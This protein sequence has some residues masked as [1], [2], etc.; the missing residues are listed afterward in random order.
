MSDGVD[1]AGVAFGGASYEDKW[2]RENIV[3]FMEPVS[4][5][6]FSAKTMNTILLDECYKRYVA[7]PGDDTT[8]LTVY[9]RSREQVNV[10]IGPPANVEDNEKMMSLFFSQK[11][12][13]WCYSRDSA[14]I[15]A[16]MLFEEATDMNFFIGPAVNPAHQGT[17]KAIT[18]STKMRLINDLKNGLEEM[19]KQ[20]RSTYF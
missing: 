20:V 10:L 17:E 3:D 1:N 2:G 13:H 4:V 16:R 11:G 14:S 6:G 15:F 18:F 19:G 9:M 12:K 5:V 7:Q 8:A